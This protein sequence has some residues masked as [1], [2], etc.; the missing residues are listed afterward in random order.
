MAIINNLP[1]TRPMVLSH[2]YASQDVANIEVPTAVVS[3]AFCPCDYECKYTEYAFGSN[4]TE[5]TNDKTRQ[6]VKLV[7]ALDTVQFTLVNAK[8]L[9]EY[10]LNA[11]TYG[12]YY[13]NGFSASNP[14]YAGVEVD[15]YSVYTLLGIGVFYIKIEHTTLSRTFTTET[16]HFQ[17]LPFNEE[18]ADNTIRIKTFHDGV[19]SSGIDYQNLEWESMVRLPARVIQKSPIQETTEFVSLNERKKTF[20]QINERVITEWTIK[21]DPIPSEVY[22][23]LIYNQLLNSVVEVSDYALFAK[24]K[25][26]NLQLKFVSVEDINWVSNNTKAVF[27]L[28]FKELDILT[29]TN[30]D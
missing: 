3:T 14:L 8:T 7:T 9:E 26:R 13:D 5:F 19:L 10:D 30:Y 23:H 21:T 17:V 1:D 29:K 12:T 22:N 6:L 2:S 11:G 16:H 24:E 4:T 25:T 28:K 18:T 20:S 27:T 15:W